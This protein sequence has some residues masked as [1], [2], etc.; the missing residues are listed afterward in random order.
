MFAKSSAQKIVRMKVG[1]RS[2]INSLTRP[3]HTRLGGAERRE[4]C[5]QTAAGVTHLIA[6]HIDCERRLVDHHIS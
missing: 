6:G 2:K 1:G 5:Q 4:P 3:R